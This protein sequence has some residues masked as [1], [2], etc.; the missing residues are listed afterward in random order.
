MSASKV[1][2]EG[3]LAVWSPQDARATLVRARKA[4][5]LSEEQEEDPVDE[6]SSE[7]AIA[8]STATAALQTVPTQNLYGVLD[9]WT[10]GDL[11][12]IK[13]VVSQE[14]H[15]EPPRRYSEASLVKQLEARG[16]GRP[17]TYGH[18]MEI[19]IARHAPPALVRSQRSSVHTL[20][21]SCTVRLHCRQYVTKENRSL[22]PTSMGRVLTTFLK[23]FFST[24]VDVQFTAGMETQLDQISAGEKDDQGFLKTFWSQLRQS[25]SVAEGVDGQQV[26]SM[27]PRSSLLCLRFLNWFFVE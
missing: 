17:S 3:Y 18:I 9:G 12:D 13:D 6:D 26:L 11:V 22:V 19:L 21:L 2:S 24:W 10:A 8:S 5:G 23:L 20:I 7:D 15:T 25:L 14:H 27:P 1:T 16:V 4:E